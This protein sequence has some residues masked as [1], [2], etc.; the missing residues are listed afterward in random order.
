MAKTEK[1]RFIFEGKDKVSKKMGDISM[2]LIGIN[3]ALEIGQK[4]VEAFK[5]AFEF[6]KQGAAAER[7]AD[8]GQRLASQ[9]D[10]SMDDIVSS[11]QMASG[12]TID[13]M[14]AM[15]AANQA[16]QLG[17]AQTPEEFEKLT[18]AAVALGR[19]TGRDA[20]QS[21][22]D[23]TTGIGRQS[24]LILDNLGITYDANKLYSEYAETLGKTAE[25]LT[26]TEKKQ[27]LINKSLEAAQPLLDDNGDLID[28]NAASYERF[29]AQMADL[30]LEWQELLA[31]GMGPF[32]TRLTEGIDANNEMQDA[33]EI[34][35]QSLR[36]IR[37]AASTAGMSVEEY[38]NKVITESEKLSQDE[39]VFGLNKLLQTK[40]TIEE[41]IPNAIDTGIDALK[42]FTKEGLAAAAINERVAQAMEDGTIEPEELI[43]I[44]SLAEYLNYDLP[45]GFTETISNFNT[46]DGELNSFDEHMEEI[47]GRYDGAVISLDVFFAFQQAYGGKLPVAPEIP[48]LPPGAPAPLFQ[49][50]G[51]FTVPSGYPNDSF[52]INVQ[53]GETVHV[54]RDGSALQSELRAVRQAIERQTEE[55][56]NINQELVKAY[57]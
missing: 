2:A 11:I 42:N 50:G 20:T 8:A 51:T 12:Q 30:K 43:G 18:K 17:V 19:A 47:F 33:M 7:L 32:L 16:M 25:Q 1:V 40:K 15:T 5:K 39:D 48:N 22:N 46:M 44:E 24:K 35:G 6:S 54:E 29:E 45:D 41:D 57:G 13:S 4:A 26:D 27:A 52:P 28:D 10:Q 38:A 49:H 34:T 53:S 31:R 23:L 37:Y 21:I 56:Y 3:Q 55:M 9:Y 36:G 14:T